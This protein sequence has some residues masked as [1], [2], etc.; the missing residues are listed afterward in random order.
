MKCV[1]QIAQQAR[2]FGSGQEGGF[3]F[4]QQAGGVGEILL[5]Q[6]PV[7]HVPANFPADFGLRQA[8]AFAEV[9]HL[10]LIVIQAAVAMPGVH[11]SL[12]VLFV[13]LN[14]IIEHGQRRLRSRA[15]VAV[16]FFRAFKER[17]AQRHLRRHVFRIGLGQRLQRIHSGAVLPRFNQLQSLIETRASVRRGGRQRSR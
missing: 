16:R 9:L 12:R 11:E 17:D 14:D 13:A 4:E 15:I 8:D 2:F 3:G 10:F 6:I 1:S 5:L 7:A